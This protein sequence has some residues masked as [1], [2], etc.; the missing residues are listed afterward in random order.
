MVRIRPLAYVLPVLA[1]L[2]YLGAGHDDAWIMLYAGETLGK[3]PWFLNHN[4]LPQEIATSFMGALLA[5][6]ASAIAPAGEEYAAW[7]IA[8]WFPALL[9]SIGIFEMLRKLCGQEQAIYWLLVLCC[10]PQW[11]YW[12]WGGVE[13][14]LYWL[15]VLWFAWTL[16]RFSATPDWRTGLSAALLAALLPLVRADALWAPLLLGY[17]VVFMRSAPLWLRLMPFLLASIVT[18]AFHVLRHA[19]TGAWLPNPAYAKAPFSFESIGNGIL[20]L[21]EF[22]ASSPLHLALAFTLPL[23]IYGTYR[24]L[25]TASAPGTLNSRLFEWCSV[26]VLV[27]DL[28]TI[29]VGGDWMVYHRFA[30]R[31]LPFKLMVMALWAHES[32][33]HGAL[34]TLSPNKRLAWAGIFL[35][36]AIS[37]FA[38]SGDV[39]QPYTQSRISHHKLHTSYAHSE[40]LSDYLIRLNPPSLRDTLALRP[41]IENELPGIVAKARGEGRLPLRIASYQ[42]G[43]FPRKLRLH[44]SPDEVLFIDLGGLSDYRIG[45]MPGPRSPL[46]LMDGVYGWAETFAYQRGALGRFL[47]GCRPDMVYVLGADERQTRLMDLAGYRPIYRMM[48]HARGQ[49][50]VGAVIFESRQQGTGNCIP[51]D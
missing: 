34:G 1:S 23:S 5:G 16:A 18:A 13:S 8:G 43:F 40:G 42:G 35:L 14:G 4:G 3:G 48:F 2:F 6:A 28:S 19:M 46:G 15:A 25:R 39:T 20:Y 33:S 32:L 41:W 7:K 27:I 49:L 17:L 30:A 47:A 31:S 22:H 12:A 36:V 21:V 9:A 26:M 50:L 24:L 45:K 29:I 11:H 44:F 10:F 51:P 38:S 37:G